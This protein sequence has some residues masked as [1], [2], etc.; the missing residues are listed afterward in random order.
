MRPAR[1]LINLDALRHN[2]AVIRQHAPDSKVLAVVKADAYGHGL[3]RVAAALQQADGFGVACIDEAEQLRAAGIKQK[4]L[5][6][7]GPYAADELPLIHKLQ[8]DIV[9]HTPEQ[10]AWLAACKPAVACNVWLKVDTGMHRLGFPAQDFSKTL[11]A[12]SAQDKHINSLHLMSHLAT[13]NEPNSELAQEQISRFADLA[14]DLTYPKSL[15]N[16]AAV[17]AWPDSHYDWVRPGLI[18]Y[19]VSPIE[20]TRASDYGLQAVMTL[21]SELI[22]VKQLRRG[23]AVGYGATW[24]CPE[25]MLVGIVAAGYGDGFPRHADATASLLVNGKRCAIVGKA[26]MDMLAVDLRSCPDAA[27]GAKVQL[28]GPDLPLEELAQHAATVPY[29]IL[30]A[31]HKRLRFIEH[32]R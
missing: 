22:A 23:D 25:D 9:I 11:A 20:G 24:S 10:L 2:L 5:L 32:G 21:E 6:L 30:C 27:V 31:V 19:G 8:L 16:S 7:E 15:A 12:I 18:L 13:A 28:W 3:V 17:L 4:I 26:S 1:V 14:R 29:Q